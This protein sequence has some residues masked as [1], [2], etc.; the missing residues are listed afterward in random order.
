M[1][2]R[3]QPST[4]SLADIECKDVLSS[5]ATPAA[6]VLDEDCA[7][8]AP[9]RN[10]SLAALERDGDES[11][12]PKPSTKCPKPYT[13]C[14]PPGLNVNLED[15]FKKLTS[16]PLP[17]PTATSIASETDTEEEEE[18]DDERFTEGLFSCAD[19]EAVKSLLDGITDLT[20][21]HLNKAITK[22]LSLG[23]SS[24]SVSA[25][26][27]GVC[28]ARE[29][30]PS[31]AMHNNLLSSISRSGPP[32]AVIAFVARMRDVLGSLDLFAAN[33]LL[34]ALAARDL[35]VSLALLAEMENGTSERYGKLPSPDIISYNT[36]LAACARAGQPDAAERLFANLETRGLTA[37]VKTFTAI[38]DAHARAD[39][40]RT[41]C[42]K[43]TAWLKRALEHN[44]RPD[45][46]MCNTCIAAYA[47]AADADG[48]ID[49][50]RMM[51]VLMPLCS[52]SAPDAVTYNTVITACARAGR[53]S[54]AESIFKAM[55]AKGLE[56]EQQTYCALL[57]AYARAGDVK[58]A[59]GVMS[60][61]RASGAE[62]DVKTY[63][64][65]MSAHAKVGDAAATLACLREMEA[66]GVRPIETTHAIVINASVR[67]GNRADAE[68][69]LVE[70]MCRGVALQ[71]SSF[72]SLITMHSKAGDAKAAATV[73]TMM[74]QRGVAPTLV[75]FN[76]LAAAWAN[77]GDIASTE[78]TAAEAEARGMK[79]DRFT[80]GALLQACISAQRNAGPRERAH[81]QGRAL[82]HATALMRSEVALN[83]VLVLS[84]KRAVGEATYARLLAEHRQPKRTAASMPTEATE[85]TVATPTAAAATNES[86]DAADG[87]EWATVKKG[88][89]RGRK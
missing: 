63:N 65:L 29:I 48:A 5:K 75:T 22:L 73:L 20:T 7:S 67:S 57:T 53:P 77:K 40:Q 12:T 43:A 49:T 46:V 84:L 23:H 83:D 80:F 58:A 11:T 45:T 64:T 89:G 72:N 71:A 76:V 85:A 66:A 39:G 25:L 82:L 18:D 52:T 26:V 47:N 68:K 28:S 79:P 54:D 35:S 60:R 2:R 69:A 61:L 27:F 74:A 17:S 62:A 34:R 37:D 16:R 86:S 32:E 59:A 10:A 4:L 21:I 42:A 24:E 51:E 38:V 30:K 88:R 1:L 50:L 55:C 81:V 36:S 41:S 3:S 56:P 14:L 44:I 15:V 9:T 8:A 13:K 70:L 31:L 87:G 78:R 19:D 33:V 6:T